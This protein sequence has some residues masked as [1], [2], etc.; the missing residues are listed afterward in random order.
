MGMGRIIRKLRNQ[1]P[2]RMVRIRRAVPTQ[3]PNIRETVTATIKRIYRERGRGAPLAELTYKTNN[4]V[5]TSTI[6]AL[7]GT[8]VGMKI[9]VGNKVPVEIGNC[10]QLKYIP[11]GVTLSMVEK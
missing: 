4:E 5:K 11:E 1:K 10:L 8:Y 3:I 6:V 2:H 9:T 7:E